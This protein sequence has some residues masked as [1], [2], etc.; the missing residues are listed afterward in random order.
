MRAVVALKI[1]HVGQRIHHCLM[2]L[3]GAEGTRRTV[4]IARSWVMAFTAVGE[5]GVGWEES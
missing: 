5:R 1:R 2:R 4:E 3:N